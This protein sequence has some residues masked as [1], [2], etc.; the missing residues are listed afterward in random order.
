[1]NYLEVLSRYMLVK[2]TLEQATKAQIGVEVWV[3]SVLNLG[4]RR[5]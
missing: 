1:V 5:R 3:Y 2:F 4:A